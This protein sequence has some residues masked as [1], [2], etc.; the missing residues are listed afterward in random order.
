MNNEILS[1]NKI[2]KEF[3]GV[4][5][6]K[7][8]AFSI[9]KG[10]VMGLVGENGAGKS[11]LIKIISGIYTP[12]SGSICVDGKIE[13]IKNYDAAKRIGISMVPQEFNLIK[14]LNVFENVFLGNEIEKTFLLHKEKMREITKEYLLKLETDLSPDV[15]IES[16]SVAQKQMV[17]I[18]KALILDAK[19]LILDEPTTTLTTKEADTLFKVMKNL[20]EKGVTIIFVSHKLK[21]V[22]SICDRVAVLRDGKLIEVCEIDKVS[23]HDIANKMIGRELSQ[24]YP[25]KSKIKNYG[26]PIFE[27]NAI[28]IDGL[29][30]DISFNLKKG[31]IVGFAGL[32]GAGRTEIAEAIIGI[33]KIDKGQIIVNGKVINVRNPKDALHHNIA[34]ISEDRQGKGI[35]RVFDIPKNI[36]FITLKEY[37]GKSHLINTKK[38]EEKTKNYVSAFGITS[39]SMRN[40][41][42]N[43]SGGN[44]Q[45]VYISRWIDTK[46]H[47]FILDEP[48]RGI[49][50]NAKLEI[51]NYM[52]NLANKGM[53]IMIISSEM[54]EIIGLCDRVYVMREGKITGHLENENI[55]EEEIM[56]YATGLK[57]G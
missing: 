24:I 22:K 2:T 45:K 9:R 15:N 23:E 57:G 19:I 49:D 46:P 44:Q 18:A 43:L 7:D 17:E 37:V 29:L 26:G 25:P 6:L 39:F 3:F 42:V 13:N 55:N 14:T 41:I 36:T 50:I 35:I 48:T 47:I 4:N 52:R 30:Y 53:A 33:R 8:I 5:V 32:V 34:Y 40:L 51:Y 20:K 27:A 21:E 54:E 38:E 56:L 1:V 28:S 31:E 10:E 12:T 11:T 16:L